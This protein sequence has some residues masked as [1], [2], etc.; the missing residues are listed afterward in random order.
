V[1]QVPTP[2]ALS[3]TWTLKWV[4]KELGSATNSIPNTSLDVHFTTKQEQIVNTS[5][6]KKL[7]LFMISQMQDFGKNV[8][9]LP[10]EKTLSHSTVKDSLPPYL[11][12]LVVIKQSHEV[13]QNLKDG[14]NT[15]LV[16]SQPSKVVMAKD[17]VC[18][19]ASSQFINNGKGI[20]KLLSVDRRNNKR[21]EEHRILFDN[22][23]DAFW[24]NYKNQKRYDCLLES[25]KKV[26]RQWWTNCSIVSPN[27][28]DM[29]KRCIGV[30]HY[31]NH[32]THY[33]Q[34]SQV[35]IFPSQF[36]FCLV[37]LNFSITSHLFVNVK[38]MNLSCTD[39]EKVN[40]RCYF[41]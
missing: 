25:L 3:H 40:L 34:M 28:K 22:K 31:E 14:M 23:K 24:L 2:S 41:D 26:V 33:L 9:H 21:V 35:K 10:I 36:M 1:L 12:D 15:H 6:A 11:N 20:S 7:I 5:I 8:K 30:R 32:A 29:V 16:G 19:F 39:L 18:I 38:L 27:R 37:S 13:V 17:I 4:Y